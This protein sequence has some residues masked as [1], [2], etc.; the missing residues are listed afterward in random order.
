MRKGSESCMIGI[1]GWLFTT[2][3]SLLVLYVAIKEAINHS[4]IASQSGEIRMINDQLDRQHQEMM[5][6]MEDLKQIISEQNLIFRE[7]ESSN[8]DRN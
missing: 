5:K 7:I 4:K 3:V 2:V 8:K 6:Q 1:F